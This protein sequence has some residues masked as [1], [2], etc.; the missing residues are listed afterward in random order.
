[1]R[2]CGAVLQS[3]VVRFIRDEQVASVAPAPNTQGSPIEYLMPSE[4]AADAVTVG[5][6]I[7]AMEADETTQ[8][9]PINGQPQVRLFGAPARA[10]DERPYMARRTE[11]AQDEPTFST[12]LEGLIP[13]T[14]TR[15]PFPTTAL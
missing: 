7:R 4:E 5:G 1:M 11:P 13:P 10:G 12:E 9:L 3:G 2:P 15:S 6:S 14:A 8:S